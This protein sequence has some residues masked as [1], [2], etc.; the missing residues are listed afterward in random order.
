MQTNITITMT[1]DELKKMIA[2]VV[3]SAIASLPQPAPQQK[4]I[5]GATETAKLL[6]ISR[7]TVG[8]WAK[9]NREAVKRI[10]RTNYYNI[11]KLFSN[12][13]KN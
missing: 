4:W 7:R 2:D 3:A 8:T 13:K 12:G 1:A 10:G 6:G 9:T 11:E 5:K